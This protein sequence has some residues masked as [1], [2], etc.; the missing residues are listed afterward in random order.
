MAM[1]SP[2]SLDA[3]LRAA[4]SALEAGDLPR[5]EAGFRAI[6]A[7]EPAH[8]AALHLLGRVAMN[9]GRGEEAL[10]LLRRAVVAAPDLAA[11]HADLG[12]L[13]AGSNQLDV[14]AESLR[15]AVS[16]RPNDADLS[17][18]GYV[19]NAAG[20]ADEAV[21][22][23]RRALELNPTH[24]LAH[25]NLGAAERSRRNFA[26]AAKHYAKAAS[27]RPKMLEARFFE[28]ICRADAGDVTGAHAAWERAFKIQ[29][30]TAPILRDIAT[31]LQRAGHAEESV[32][33]LRQ[34][35][36]LAPTD[37]AAWRLLAG[38][39][40]AAADH[41]GA[42]AAA[43][44]VLR[45]NPNLHEARLDLAV[46]LHD[47]LRYDDAAAELREYLRH[48][49]NSARAHAN[50]GEAISLAAP[51]G[52]RDE[53][54][55]ALCRRA[56]ELDPKDVNLHHHLVQVLIRSC[57]PTEAAAA[58]RRAVEVAPNDAE[59]V[60][61]LG[62]ALQENLEFEPAL[63]TMRRA[64]EMNPHH[65]PALLMLGMVLLRHGQYEEGFRLYEHRP[66]L[67][68]IG[69]V[70]WDGSP[71]NGRP[72]VLRTEQGYGDAI[73]FVRYATV[74][75]QLGGQPI[76]LCHPDLARLFATVPGVDQIVSDVA[77]LKDV[78]LEA[79]LMSLPHLLGTRL[80]NVPAT[81]PYFFPPTPQRQELI[82][83]LSSA[84]GQPRIGLV[85]SG[86]PL[87]ANNRRRSVPLEMFR[88]FI[89]A[90][91]HAK[92]YSLQVGSVVERDR[93]QIDSLGLISLA[94]MLGDFTDTAWVINQLDLLI[95]VDTSV[96]H[97]AGALG[98]PVW[99]MLAWSSDWRWLIE[100]EDNPWYPTMRLFTQASPT[101][102]PAIVDRIA[103]ELAARFKGKSA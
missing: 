67:P 13:L 60:L 75:Q 54:A 65:D 100:R 26:E 43:R 80:D 50:L 76:V 58:A 70:P 24:V 49:P 85:W 88:A 10:D 25:C 28:G 57:R 64:I 78:K 19:L 86:N 55:I 93:A 22:V 37:A 18:L 32:R 89:D 84:Q 7:R 56:T 14:A 44:Q 62:V 46:A 42:E 87:Y 2:Q 23:L 90:V 97:L 72:I 21:E 1:T 20:R 69:L 27:L 39:L 102:W 38:A 96:A 31:V 36:Q 33:Y 79:P 12:R 63:A 73:H 98:R 29:P 16:L 95:T 59:A 66:K 48:D 8:A 91:P 15:K 53:E 11:A 74:I 41:A 5:A 4:R 6:L 17:D 92:F 61:N 40:S 82:D 52:S 47:Q 101:D 68:P 34:A 77:N 71:L 51:D 81:V 83:T 45:L 3:Q 103:R 94:K 30:A 99:A 9:S 35:T